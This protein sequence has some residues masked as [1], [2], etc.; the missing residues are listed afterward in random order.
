[1]AT[2][3]KVS[4]AVNIKMGPFLD[5]D[6]GKTVEGSLTI[7]QPDVRL[8][9]N[10]GDFAQ[11]NAAQT[12][13]HNE[14]GWYT[15]ALNDTDTN[16]LGILLVHIHETPGALPVW[17]EF[18]VVTANVWDALFAG[19]GVG[20]RANVSGWLG[21]VPTTP[22]TAGVPNV[23]LARI[24]N[25]A[26]SASTA[27]LGVNAVNIGGTAQTGANLAAI[28]GALTDAAATASDPGTTTTLMSF[29]KQLI[30]ILVGAAGVTSYPAE[31][32]PGNAVSLAEVIS[33]IHADV[34]GLAGVTNAQIADQVW[35]EAAG[36]HVGG[37]SMGEE[38]ASHATVAEVN[39]EVVDALN[40]DTYA[41]P[42]QGLPPATA[43]LVAKLNYLYKAWRN[44]I[45][46]NKSTG[47][48]SLFNDDATTV[49]QKATI[50]DDA[51]TFDK[52]EIASGP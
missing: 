41:E 46:L 40:V 33:A 16:T 45:T 21:E 26:V 32:A 24:V 50:S 38:M 31:S 52:G 39:A 3:L 27:Q 22:G 49:D 34:T 6:D 25:A 19:T 44:R 10:G 20:I 30:N 36:D 4:T 51:T 18:N 2:F 28:I 9:K 1:M 12:L 35:D 15:V 11:K 47:Q 14:K 7:T 29:V 8:S 5:E 13:T 17:R 43:S 37:G 42:G 48:Y 23:D